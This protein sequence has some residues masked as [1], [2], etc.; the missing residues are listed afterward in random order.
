MPVLQSPTSSAWLV[1]HIRSDGPHDHPAVHRLQQQIRLTPLSRWPAEPGQDAPPAVPA[2]PPVT[3][4]PAARVARM[5]PHEYFGRVAALLVDNPPHRADR[6]RMDRMSVLGVAR[7]RPPEWSREHREHVR[8]VARGM[9]EGLAQIESV[10]S[11]LSSSRASWTCPAD[12]GRRPADPL[13]RAAAAWIGLGILPRA[14]GL[15]HATDC[16]AEGRRLTG[17]QRYVLRFPPGAAPPARAFWSLTTH[18]RDGLVAAGT[19]SRVPAIGSRDQLRHDPDGYLTI[20]IQAEAPE[21]S[22]AN[23]LPVR[24]GPFG[25]ALRLYWPRPAA[26]DGTWS[27]PA[28]VR[29]ACG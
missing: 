5:D 22:P 24:P 14:D 28:V 3:P 1:A 27:P 19:D 29:V 13:M 12:L 4:S 2:S 26:L 9:A 6:A 21:S 11:A 8:E 16:D 10:A 23:W 15:V 20:R 17:T 18:P 25:L 7:G